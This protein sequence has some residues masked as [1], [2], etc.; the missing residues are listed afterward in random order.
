MKQDPWQQLLLMVMLLVL[1]LWLF[2]AT[3]N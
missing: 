3:S 2:S 1:L